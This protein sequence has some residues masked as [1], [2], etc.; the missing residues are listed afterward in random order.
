IWRAHRRIRTITEPVIVHWWVPLGWLAARSC[1]D[2]QIVCHGTDL[3]ILNRHRFLARLLAPA[4]RKV[5][6]WQCVSAHLKAVLCSLYPF[7]PD[8]RVVVE[9]MPLDP[10]FQNRRLPREHFFVSVGALIPLKRHHLAIDY[11]A[12]NYPDHKLIIVGEGPLQDELRRHADRRGVTVEL[13]PWQTPETLA[14]LFNRAAGLLSFSEH[15]GY[16]LVLREAKACGCR[17]IG[18]VGDGRDE[19]VVD[20]IIGRVNRQ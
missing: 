11:V 6:R 8:D 16:G 5:K 4:A 15:E 13:L 20:E 3:K 19:S 14:D 18:Y 7:I 17:V 2:V 10:V 1:S 12:D 9:P